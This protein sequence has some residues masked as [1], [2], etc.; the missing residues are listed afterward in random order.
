MNRHRKQEKYRE[1]LREIPKLSCDIKVMQDRGFDTSCLEEKLAIKQEDLKKLSQERYH[2]T[3]S[4]TSNENGLLVVVSAPSGT[5]KTTLCKKLLEIV[6]NLRFSVSYTTRPPRQGEQN[7]IDYYFISEA[8]FKEK[9]M[10]GEFAEWA[11]NYGQLYGTSFREIKRLLDEKIDVLL[12]VDP[13]GAKALK[14]SYPDAIF[15]FVLPPSTTVLEARLRGRGSERDDMLQIRLNK[16]MDEME[17]AL[18]YDYVIINEYIEDSLDILRSIY[19][20]EKNK[21]K[22]LQTVLQKIIKNRR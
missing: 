3:D 19:T 16:A 6:Q 10:E 12:D 11:E 15:I 20:A 18:W 13:R 4:N 7:G 8:E 5:G 9:I 1:L 22:R 21:R 14:K 17:E 2:S